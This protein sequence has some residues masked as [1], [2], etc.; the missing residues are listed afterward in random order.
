[1]KCQCFVL[2]Y[3]CF[4]RQIPG[5]FTKPV[6]YPE[7]SLDVMGMFG[8][9]LQLCAQVLDMSID[10]AFV[11]LVGYTLDCFKQLKAGES[12]PG[13]RRHGCQQGELG[14]GPIQVLGK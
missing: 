8:I 14:R 5:L 2:K 7:Y 9:E 4:A 1:M 11:T 10:G 13:L 12:A 3:L 6:T